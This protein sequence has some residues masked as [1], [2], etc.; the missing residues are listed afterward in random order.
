[1]ESKEQSIQSSWVRLGMA[2][3]PAG[4]CT[5]TLSAWRCVS[6]GRGDESVGK[7]LFMA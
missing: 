3:N 5:Y 4:A 7:R 2:S 1:M 6:V